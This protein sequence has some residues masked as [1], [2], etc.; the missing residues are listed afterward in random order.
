VAGFQYEEIKKEARRNSIALPLGSW[1]AEIIIA[2]IKKRAETGLPLAAHTVQK[3]D[4]R[5]YSASVAIFG[6]WG[7][8]VEAAAYDYLEHRKTSHWD[9]E[10]ILQRIKEAY[11]NGADLNDNNVQR[12]APALDGA[13]RAVFGSWQK[14]IEAAGLSYEKVSRTVRWSRAKIV[15]FIA[16]A[17][18]NGRPLTV[19]NFPHSFVE[20]TIDVFGSWKK[21]LEAAGYGER[22]W[23]EASPKLKNHI[24][25]LRKAAGLS[26]AELGKRL[27]VSHR[28]ISMLEL[29]QYIDPRVSFAIKIARAL[30][31][32]VEEVFEIREKDTVLEKTDSK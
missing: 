14:A 1:S 31:R 12:L 29:G 25:E 17:V 3:E 9:E 13:A 16:E 4:S 18:K 21:A 32:P 5:L 26:E 10:K 15:S 2:E 6:P 27:G 11:T 8:A 23:N 19:T 20:A 24:R 30:G 28:T 22:L 7:K